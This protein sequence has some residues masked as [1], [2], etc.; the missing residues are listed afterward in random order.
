MKMK[1]EF[2]QKEEIN[3]AGLTRARLAL[4]WNLGTWI[5]GASHHPN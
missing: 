2:V 4:G 1:V 3:I 5:S